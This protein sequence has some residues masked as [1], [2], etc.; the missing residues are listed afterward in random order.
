MYRGIGFALLELGYDNQVHS[1][2]PREKCL[3]QHAL[4]LG[5]VLVWSPALIGP[6][7]PLIAI[8]DI[9]RCGKKITCTHKEYKAKLE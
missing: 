1:P 3:P 8:T 6:N 9:A 7:D 2:H 5:C 4:S